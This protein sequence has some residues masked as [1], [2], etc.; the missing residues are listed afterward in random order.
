VRSFMP[1][2][3]LREAG[4]LPKEEPLPAPA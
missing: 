2:R 1:V 3:D 4:E